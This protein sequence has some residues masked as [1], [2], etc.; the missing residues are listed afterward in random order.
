M[1][2]KANRHSEHTPVDVF[3]NVEAKATHDEAQ[4]AN[5]TFTTATFADKSIE[6]SASIAQKQLRTQRFVEMYLTHKA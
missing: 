4:S 6:P 3:V 2:R 1:L 5:A